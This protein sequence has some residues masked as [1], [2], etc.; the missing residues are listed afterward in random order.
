MDLP[1]PRAFSLIEMAQEEETR[2]VMFRL[3]LSDRP[4]MDK[5]TFMTFKE[6]YEKYKPK[7]IVVDKRSKEQILE[8]L[9]KAR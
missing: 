8:E 3:Y 6:Y 9:L 7:N 4:N 2:E 1:L 5:K